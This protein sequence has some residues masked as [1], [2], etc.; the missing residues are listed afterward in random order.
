MKKK[1]KLITSLSININ[2]VNSLKQLEHL[3]NKH[4][5]LMIQEYM[6][7]KEYGAD[8]YIDLLTGELKTI[9]LKEKLLMRSGETD[10][11]ISVRNTII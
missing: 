2:K 1:M 9:F 3:F 5:G 7:G 11:S 4:E 8:V 6:P 10:K